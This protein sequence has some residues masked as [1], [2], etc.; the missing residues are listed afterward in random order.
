MASST[1]VVESSDS[2]SV[3]GSNLGLV[4]RAGRAVGSGPTSDRDERRQ[5]E[6]TDCGRSPCPLHTSPPVPPQSVCNQPPLTYAVLLCFTISC[7]PNLTRRHNY[8]WVCRKRGL[9][10]IQ[11]RFAHGIT[12]LQ[13][14]ADLGDLGSSMCNGAGDNLCVA[15]CTDAPAVPHDSGLFPEKTYHG[16]IQMHLGFR[17]CRN[18]TTLVAGQIRHSRHISCCWSDWACTRAN[19]TTYDPTVNRSRRALYS[20][21]PQSRAAKPADASIMRKS[22]AA[23]PEATPSGDLTHGG[24]GMRGAVVAD[25]QRPGFSVDTHRQLRQACSG[26]VKFQ[27]RRYRG[28]KDGVGRCGAGDTAPVKDVGWRYPDPAVTKKVLHCGEPR[29][30]ACVEGVFH[31]VHTYQ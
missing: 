7:G 1:C 9:R 4:G 27:G 15:S 17:G 25:R 19:F 28:V 5:M 18:A 8:R 16:S 31:T 26:N 23:D 29:P 22:E 11:G 3:V 10:Q 2:W 6:C 20:K 14:P 24:R 12:E 13:G 21:R 30:T